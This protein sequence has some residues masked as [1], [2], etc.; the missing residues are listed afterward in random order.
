MERF[1]HY[2]IFKR[3]DGS[4]WE[5]GRGAMGVTYRAQDTLLHREVALKVVNNRYLE[6]DTARQRF[7]REARAAA[8]ITHEN[9]AL[10]YQF[11]VEEDS[12][13]YAMEYVRGAYAGGPNL[14]SVPQDLAI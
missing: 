7:Q 3:E 12:C 5:L 13:Y 2:E 6:N 9:V 14:G 4:L 11:G 8:R 10:V 1:Q